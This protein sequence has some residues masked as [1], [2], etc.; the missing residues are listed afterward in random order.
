MPGAGR[1]FSL[2]PILLLVGLCA[3]IETTGCSE[4]DV[5]PPPEF[6]TL[7]VVRTAAEL[8]TALRTI[9][10]GDTIEIDG[11]F[12]SP[13]FVMSQ[14]YVF[15]ADVS[16]ILIR[17]TTRS[18]TRPEIVFPPNVNAL[19]FRGHDGTRLTRLSFKGGATTIVMADSRV[20]IDTLEIRNP[21][22]DGVEAMGERSTGRVRGCLI[23]FRPVAAGGFGGRF[24]VLTGD[25][26]QLTIDKNTIVDAG[27]CGMHIGSNDTVANNNII[28]AR[29]HGLYFDEA[30]ST[31][32]VFCNNA[33]LSGTANYGTVNEIGVPGENNFAVNPQFCLGSYRLSEASGLTAANS[34]G[35]GLIGA[36][37]VEDGC[38]R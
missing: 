28:R 12:A 10:S 17:S 4:D 1:F 33:F 31:P 9:T 16:P 6:P 22:R 23:E 14:G 38:P 19:T 35:C 3:L 27:D 26:S 2:S 11:G 21:A 20:L 24:G 32:T 36:L 13:Q 5:P 25:R 7:R 29:L 15:E 30:S 18:T 37:E 34:G 8:D